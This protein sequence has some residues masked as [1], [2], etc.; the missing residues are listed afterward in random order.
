MPDKEKIGRTL[1]SAAKTVK[2]YA[3]MSKGV[4]KTFMAGTSGSGSEKDIDYGPGPEPK[5]KTPEPPKQWYKDSPDK[6]PSYKQGTDYVPETGPAILHEGE[7]VV[8]KEKNMADENSPVSKI[9][10]ALGSAGKKL[11]APQDDEGSAIAEKNRMIDEYKRATETPSS[12]PK[13]P[14]AEPQKKDPDASKGPNRYGT[15]KG[16]KRI[17]TTEMVRP[18]GSFEKGTDNVPKDGVYKLHAGEAVLNEND[19]EQHRAKKRVGDA[20]GGGAGKKPKLSAKKGTKKSVHHTTVHKSENGGVVIQHEFEDGTKGMMQHHSNF[21]S[22]AN[23]MR[24]HFS[25]PGEQESPAEDNAEGGEAA[26]AQQAPPQ[27][28]AQLPSYKDGIDSVP[29][30]GPAILHEGEAVIPAAQNVSDQ[31]D[32]KMFSKDAKGNPPPKRVTNPKARHR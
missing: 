27:S 28:A 26:E 30:T 5:P 11:A 20:L 21:D 7:A 1:G 15:R 12:T 10:S 8:P 3:S 9:A 14:A 16:E 6:L 32:I 23:E 19:A 24:Q 18:L 17:D 4:A 25:S 29:K 2:D 22:A 31:G 13:P